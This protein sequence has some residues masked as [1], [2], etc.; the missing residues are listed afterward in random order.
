MNWTWL[1]LITAAFL[2][3]SCFVGF[4]RGFIKEAVSTFLVI[5]SFVGVW[6]VNPYVNTFIRENTPVYREIQGG[7]EEFVKEKTGMTG[8]PGTEEKKKVL[9]EMG[10][11]EIIAENILKNSSQETYSYLAAQSFIEYISGY[12][13]TL[14]VNGISFLLSFFLVT[15]SIRMVTYALNL[16]AR[17]PVIHGVNKIAGGLLGGVK[18]IL[19]IWVAMLVLTIFCETSVGKAGFEMIEKDNMLRVLYENNI[20]AKLFTGIFYGR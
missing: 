15:V 13:A 5:L 8:E 18:A 17:L 10:V 11:P 14:V 7:V 20:L 6:F 4:R 9:E 2:V 19:F 12:L 16:I 3:F 1:G